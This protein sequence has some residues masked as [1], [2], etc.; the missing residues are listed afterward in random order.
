ML[1]L[2]DFYLHHPEPLI[3]WPAGMRDIVGRKNLTSKEAA[4]LLG[5][6]EA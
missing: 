1:V 3:D 4:R 5:V 2:S 6:S